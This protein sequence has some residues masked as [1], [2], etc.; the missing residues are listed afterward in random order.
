MTN[1]IRLLFVILFASIVAG[2]DGCANGA[3]VGLA[4][5]CP[6]PIP[7]AGLWQDPEDCQDYFQC[8]S[9][10]TAV[11]KRCKKGL[12][13]DDTLKVCNHCDLVVCNGGDGT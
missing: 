5:A 13:F 3:C 10:N 9:N 1:K 8:A 7:R 12:C 11:K 4:L 2:Q 6:D